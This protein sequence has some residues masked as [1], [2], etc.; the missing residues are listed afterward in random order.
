MCLTYTSKQYFNFPP[1][2]STFFGGGGGGGER[3]N[4]DIYDSS[5][6]SVCHSFAVLEH[7]ISKACIWMS[8]AA[9][10]E[11]IIMSES[12]VS[13]TGYRW[14]DRIPTVLTE[15]LPF[16]TNKLIP[17]SEIETIQCEFKKR[18]P[19][20]DSKFL[21]IEKRYS[22]TGFQCMIAVIILLSFGTV[23]VH[24]Y[25][26]MDGCTAINFEKYVKIVLVQVGVVCALW[27]HLR[28]LS[29]QSNNSCIRTAL[30]TM[31]KLYSA[32]SGLTCFTKMIAEQPS[33]TQ[34][35]QPNVPYKRQT[36]GLVNYATRNIRPRRKCRSVEWR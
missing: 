3:R 15:I 13:K 1:S 22:Q 20:F 19:G 11:I 16:K 18:K 31:T 9:L 21:K 8:L 12:L 17:W 32:M 36:S 35:K 29:Q 27:W 5:N 28:E 6:M 30:C 4:S 34:Y 10:K 7:N 23:I 26:A 14:M 33:L 24:S 2:P 25:L